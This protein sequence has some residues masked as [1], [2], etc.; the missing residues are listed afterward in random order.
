MTSCIH[1]DLGADQAKLP[2]PS[3]RGYPSGQAEAGGVSK[4]HL[5]GCISASTMHRA[6]ELWW[7]ISA[8]AASG[9]LPGNTKRA[10]NRRRL[11][12]NRFE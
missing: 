6:A 7:C 5:V 1:P 11:F 8:A 10:G 12:V 3:H 2:R 4:C 9:T